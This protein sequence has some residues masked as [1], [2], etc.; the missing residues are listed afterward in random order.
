[1]NAARALEAADL[2]TAEVKVLFHPIRLEKVALRR[3][4]RWMMRVWGKSIQAI[5]L[6]RH[7]F[8][9]P[10]VLDGN[11]RRL[12][13]LVVHELTHVR[14]WIDGGILSFAIPY[15]VEYVRGRLGGLSHR[16]AYLAISFEEEAR[17][18]SARFK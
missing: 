14:Q 1:M 10:E 15:L 17:A 3:A 9:D 11:P 13:L 12:G 18:M 4:P 5:T 16:D 6:A 7:I 2:A 8:I